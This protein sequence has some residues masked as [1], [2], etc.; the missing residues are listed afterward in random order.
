M[1]KD[2]AKRV[3]SRK[4]KNPNKKGSKINKAVVVEETPA[5]DTEDI[6]IQS[7][8]SAIFGGQVSSKVFF[9]IR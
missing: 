6:I 5:E 3:Y 9:C 4:R 8:T 7:R 2:G 1:K